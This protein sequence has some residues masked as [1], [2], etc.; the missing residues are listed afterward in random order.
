M[1]EEQIKDQDRGDLEDRMVDLKTQGK[2]GVGVKIIIGII[3][4]IAIAAGIVAAV[5]STR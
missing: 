5:V 3:V 4:V 2:L 1:N